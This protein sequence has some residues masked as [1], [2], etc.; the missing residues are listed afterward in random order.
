MSKNKKT[1]LVDC[2]NTYLKWCLFDGTSLTQQQRLFHADTSELEAFKS[3]IDNHSTD[4]NSI[5]MVS[6]LGDVF[7]SGA[8]LLAE[9]AQLNFLD[10]KSEKYLGDIVNAYTEPEKLG[11]DRLVAMVGAYEILENNEACIVIDSGTATTI[12]ALD[13]TGQHLGG[14]IFPGFAL[15]L[16]G[17]SNNTHLL[18]DFDVEKQQIQNQGLAKNTPDAIATGCLL[19][20]ASAIDGICNKMKSHMERANQDSDSR[21]IIVKRILCGG[22][23]EVLLPHLENEYVCQENLIMIGLK[24]LSLK[25]QQRKDD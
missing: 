21:N 12:D 18:P 9:N 15:N 13:N 1:I 6:V 11:S 7:A 14:V 2:G 25:E 10:V 19:S 22:A 4:C 5:V 8:K 17:L 16:K 23:T 20:L 3:L 24:S